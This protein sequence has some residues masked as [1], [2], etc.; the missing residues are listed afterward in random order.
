MPHSIICPIFP[1]HEEE[2]VV[3]FAEDLLVP[4]LKEDLYSCE[5]PWLI[6]C[7]EKQCSTREKT[8]FFR[9][10]LAGSGERWTWGRKSAVSWA[11]TWS[12]WE[13]SEKVLLGMKKCVDKDLEDPT[14][15]PQTNCGLTVICIGSESW[16]T[17]GMI[18]EVK[19]SF[20]KPHQYSSCPTT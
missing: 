6:S 5:N 4:Y 18:E 13:T 2:T 10:W 16:Q 15:F 9:G 19:K 1:V 14:N 8:E 11:K 3:S 20:P 7:L 17:W 12:W